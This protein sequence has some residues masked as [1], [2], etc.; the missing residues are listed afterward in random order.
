VAG[1]Q[2][3]ALT[4]AVTFHFI[5][6]QVSTGPIVAQVRVHDPRS[7]T[8]GT[9]AAEC[10]RTMVVLGIVWTGDAATTPRPLSINAVELALRS[11]H[12]SAAIV[13]RASDRSFQCANDLDGA[14]TYF[15]AA[16]SRVWPLVTAIEIEPSVAARERA[17]HVPAGAAGALTS[18]GLA[19]TSFSRTPS[20][21]WSEEC[22]W[23]AV[24]NVAVVVRTHH[25]P[26]AADR[27][28]LDRLA[29]AL[30]RAASG[31]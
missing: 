19:S 12:A 23:L 13:P 18:S 30:E 22:R 31:G 1:T 20:G 17:L 11:L 25:R 15:L 16:P 4:D 28:F 24:S 3:Q 9:A 26:T 21:S 5:L 10:D 2:E 29:A 27:A 6:D 7:S 8:C 14:D